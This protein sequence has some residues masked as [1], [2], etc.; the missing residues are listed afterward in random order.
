VDTSF[1][2]GLK[3][4]SEVHNVCNLS[5]STMKWLLSSSVWLKLGR[6]SKHVWFYCNAACQTVGFS[7]ACPLA[8]SRDIN[9]QYFRKLISCDCGGGYRK[10]Q[11]VIGWFVPQSYSWTLIFQLDPSLGPPFLPPQCYPMGPLH[12]HLFW[13]AQM[14]VGTKGWLVMLYLSGWNCAKSKLSSTYL[15]LANLGK[16]M[17]L[18]EFKM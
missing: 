13:G 3:M 16:D 6:L 14:C 10:R 7:T 11:W 12:T 9:G 2:Q 18:F 15:A 8:R 5:S 4:S 17:A 1:L